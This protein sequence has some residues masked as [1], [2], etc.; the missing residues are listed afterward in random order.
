VIMKSNKVLNSLE[1]FSCAINEKSAVTKANKRC[2][3][4][5]KKQ[6]SK[7]TSLILRADENLRKRLKAIGPQKW[8]EIIN[9]LPSKSYDKAMRHIWWDYFSLRKCTERHNHLDDYL[10]QP[11]QDCTD[12]EL[13]NALVLSGFSAPMAFLRVYKTFKVPKPTEKEPNPRNGMKEIRLG[14]DSGLWIEK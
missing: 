14:L 2:G 1:D 6:V 12:F 5:Q 8:R 3:D 10:E 4:T 7:E 9:T 11:F 13:F